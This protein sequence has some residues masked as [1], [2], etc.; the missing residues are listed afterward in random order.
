MLVFAALLL[1]GYGYWELTSDAR[2]KEKVVAYL[3]RRVA[4]GRVE[5]SRAQFSLFGGIRVENLRVYLPGDTPNPFFE[6][7]TV[8]LHHRPWGLL[9]GGQLAPSEIVCTEPRVT[10]VEDVRTGKLNV[11]RLFPLVGR[12][13]SDAGPDL[14]SL[15]SIRLRNGEL[16]REDLE[17]GQ[18]CRWGG[19]EG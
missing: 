6:A 1:L 18:I 9:F 4:G 16:I 14:S 2:V 12:S 11:M 15:P 7:E 8:V 3:T 19:G 17:D 10:L 13:R 5:L